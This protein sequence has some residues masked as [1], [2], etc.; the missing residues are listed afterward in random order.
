MTVLARAS[1][2]CKLQTHPLIKR[3]LHKDYESKYSVDKKMLVVSLKVLVAK[4]N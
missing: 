3:M 1:S 4:T 2:N